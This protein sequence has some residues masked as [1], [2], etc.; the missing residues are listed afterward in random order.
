MCGLKTTSPH[1]LSLES[2]SLR[3][4]E[5]TS[6]LSPDFFLFRGYGYVINGADSFA[7]I[8]VKA[9]PSSHPTT[10]VPSHLPPQLA[11][12]RGRKQAGM[13]SALWQLPAAPAFQPGSHVSVLSKQFRPGKQ[14]RQQHQSS[15]GRRTAPGTSRR[16]KLPASQPTPFITAASTTSHTRTHNLHHLLTKSSQDVGEDSNYLPLPPI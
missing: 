12:G 7:A 2:K 15:N 11:R 8:S 6:Q 4:G 10:R 14:P 9:R 3:G 16:R 1:G 13:A 5:L